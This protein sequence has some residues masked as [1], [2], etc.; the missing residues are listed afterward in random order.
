MNKS[1][2]WH[3]ITCT[4]YKSEDLNENSDIIRTLKDTH[5]TTTKRKQI[6]YLSRRKEVKI[7]TTEE[8][9]S[10]G[11]RRKWEQIIMTEEVAA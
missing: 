10:G 1:T 8:R 11:Q 5:K 2:D 6:N 7:G 3:S 9:S 4:N